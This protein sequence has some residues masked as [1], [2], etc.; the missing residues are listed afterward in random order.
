[1]GVERG[2]APV[3][4]EALT[5]PS[6]PSRA[7][8]MPMRIVD[9]GFRPR[10]MLE[11]AEALELVRRAA[12]AWATAEEAAAA[13]AAAAAA[14]PQSGATS[15]TAAGSAGMSLDDPSLVRL[16]QR[17]AV[18]GDTIHSATVTHVQ[19]LWAGMGAVL[20]VR[21]ETAGGRAG[22]SQPVSALLIIKKVLLPRGALSFGAQAAAPRQIFVV[23]AAA[24]PALVAELNATARSPGDAR[25]KVSYECESRF[26]EAM[27]GQLR[28]LGCSVPAGL[29]VD[30]TPETIHIVMSKMPGSPTLSGPEP[31]EGDVAEREAAQVREYGQVV[32]SEESDE[33]GA[34]CGGGL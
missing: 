31:H 6:A 15:A 16:F 7:A 11:A 34:R 12:D 24:L 26:Y 8:V 4:A 10:L 32:F 17:H 3:A 2:S 27:A 18:D 21:A 14:G 25:K 9:P 1:M 29:L 13:A 19:R 20:E 30:R 28:V 23:H 33:P 22:G 5:L